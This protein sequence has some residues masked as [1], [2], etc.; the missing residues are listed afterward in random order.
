MP[1]KCFPF[2]SVQSS[3]PWIEWSQFSATQLWTRQGGWLRPDATLSSFLLTDHVSAGDLQ[4]EPLKCIRPPLPAIPSLAM[5]ACRKPVRKGRSLP[6]V[7]SQRHSESDAN[8][9]RNNLDVLTQVKL[10]ILQVQK[11]KFV[12]I[13]PT[14]SQP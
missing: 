11:S 8:K 5:P 6:I 14:N 2:L 13:P 7:C 4:R 10:V 9:G 1:P 3:F 12:S